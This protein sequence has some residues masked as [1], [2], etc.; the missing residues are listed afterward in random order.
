[1]HIGVFGHTDKRPF[2]YAMLK[3]LQATGDVALIS[4]NRHYTRLLEGYVSQGHMA[5]IF[6]SVSDATPDEIFEEIG[7]APDDFDH[8]VYDI[9][10][11]VPAEMDLVVYIKTY[12]LDDD[13][14]SFLEILGDVTTINVL[15]YDNKAEKDSLNVSL[16]LPIWKSVEMFEAYRVLEPMKS[17]SLTN[18]IAKLLTPK[19]NMSEKSALKVLARGWG[20]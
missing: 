5:N 10:D 15:N 13:A 18:A 3:L 2:I 16:T 20:S 8:I 7:Q 9:V 19:L 1:M 12:D 11:T 17:N 4:N 14:Q 6:I